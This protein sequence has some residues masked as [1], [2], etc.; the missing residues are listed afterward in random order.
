M[1]AHSMTSLCN[2]TNQLSIAI[3]ASA[4]DYAGKQSM[5]RTVIVLDLVA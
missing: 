2:C 3:A 5:E 1:R 4:F